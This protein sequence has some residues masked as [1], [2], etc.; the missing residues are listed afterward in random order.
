MS[1]GE[2]NEAYDWDWR[3]TPEWQAVE[4]AIADLVA[5][6]P[7]DGPSMLTDFVVVANTVPVETG[8]DLV[9]TTNIFC[10]SK[11]PYVAR[12]LLSHGLDIQR[13]L[14]VPF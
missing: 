1:E 13:E 12:G 9:G 7:E 6:D 14:E 10:T 8:G 5:L 2:A 11:H 4:K 3:E